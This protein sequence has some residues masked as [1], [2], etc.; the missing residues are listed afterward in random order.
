MCDLGTLP[1]NS[2]TRVVSGIGGRELRS[3]IARTLLER[4]GT[5]ELGPTKLIS[6]DPFGLVETTRTIP[7]NRSITVLPHFD[8]LEQFVSPTGMLP[9]GKALR[10]KTLETTPYATGIREYQPGDPLSR[11]HWKATAKTGK[12]MVKEFEQD[13]HANVWVLL[14]ANENVRYSKR[15]E[16]QSSPQDH[17]WLGKIGRKVQL[18]Q[19]TFEYGVSISASVADY[20]LRLGKAVGFASAGQG[21]TVL[22]PEKGERQIG[23]LLEI[24]ALLKPVGKMELL[25]LIQG[26]A[27]N[28]TRGSIVVLVTSAWDREVPIAV[29]YF[30]ER[31]LRPVVVNIDPASFGLVRSSSTMLEEVKRLGVPLYLV[32]S[33]DAI[34]LALSRPIN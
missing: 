29:E 3:Y 14:D 34:R 11:I 30:L 5:F 22:S 16:T 12:M 31:D 23:K 17:F 32:H 4:R 13:M 24:L 18:P 7:G 10:S 25:G 20:Y 26:V 2:A 15:E 8:L 9:G 28:I 19:D 33:G 1:N 21:L 6:G 27:A